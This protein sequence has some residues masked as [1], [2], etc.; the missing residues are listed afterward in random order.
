MSA[1]PSTLKCKMFDGEFD[2]HNVPCISFTSSQMSWCLCV[3]QAKQYLART[4]T[5][6]M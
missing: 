1:A 3:P 5:A 6:L 4:A 2:V